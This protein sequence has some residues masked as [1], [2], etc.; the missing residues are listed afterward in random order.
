MPG[1]GN[2]T[3]MEQPFADKRG[4]PVFEELQVLAHDERVKEFLVHD[5]EPRT[6]R[7]FHG[8]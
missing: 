2:V 7:S 6:A 8:S 4:R 1:F 5:V 3:G